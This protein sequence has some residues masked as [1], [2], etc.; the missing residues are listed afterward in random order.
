MTTS[1]RVQAVMVN[2]CAALNHCDEVQL[3][4]NHN[5]KCSRV[6]D[7]NKPCNCIPEMHVVT[8][9]YEFMVDER[10]NVIPVVQM[11]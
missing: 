1:E 8:S 2:L 5:P 11:N 3:S 9:T 7:S 6:N 4:L 10:G